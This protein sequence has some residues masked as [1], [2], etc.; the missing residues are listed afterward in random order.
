MTWPQSPPPFALTALSGCYFIL[1]VASLSVVGLLDPMAEGLQ[2]S[3]SR[4]AYLVTAFALTYAVMAPVLQILVG[5]WDRRRL[6]LLGLGAIG[7]GSLIMA[8]A[9]GYGLAAAGRVVM[10]VGAAVAGPMAS[11]EGAALVPPERRGAA[12]GK[13]FAGM[14]LATVLGVPLTAFAGTVIG[15]RATLIVIAGVAGLVALAVATKVPAG[16][17]GQKSDAKA[18]IETLVNPVL[19]PAIGVTLFQ[20]AAQ[21]VTY[22]VIAAFLAD[23]F[24]I[25]ETLLPLALFTFGIGGILGNLLATRLSDRLGPAKLIQISLAVT[26]GVFIC[27]Q[28]AP[29]NKAVAFILMGAWSIFGMMLFAPQQARLIS[30]APE[31]TNLLLALNGSA[32]YLG[33]AGGAALSGMLYAK[34]GSDGLAW[35][36]C[37][38]VVMAMVAMAASEHAQKKTGARQG[39]AEEHQ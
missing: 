26:M 11:A 6:L 17:R 3:K 9:P 36:S 4:I 16:G 23:R 21:F 14:T 1:A 32:I 18:V 31:R 19:A 8:L 15:W 24:A 37:V 10:A 38:L 7:L 2:V 13:V 25:G 39:Q 34:T 35:V 22:A 12:L 33:M 20:M 5:D 28:L 27:L 30:L 29:S